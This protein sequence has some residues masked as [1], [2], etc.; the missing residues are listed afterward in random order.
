MRIG[1]V[2]MLLKDLF[3]NY[4]VKDDL[5]IDNLQND[6]RL[7]NI[8]SLFIAYTGFEK[9]PHLYIE[10]AYCNGCR[11]F[12]IDSDKASQFDG[13]YTD[14][15]FISSTDLKKEMVQVTLH[16]Y[17]YPDQKL[18]LIGV[19]GTNG[20]TTT[21]TVIDQSINIIGEKTAFFGTVEWRVGDKSY[22]ALNTTPD[23]LVLVKFLKQA[24]D[25]DI[26]YVVMEVASHALSLGRVDGL[27]FDFTVFTNLTQDHLD[28]H[29]TLEEY[30]KAKERLFVDLLAN[31]NKKNKKAFINADDLHGQRLLKILGERGVPSIA[32]SIEDKGYWN[33][34]NVFAS[35]YKTR[36]T[37][38]T[39]VESIIIESG[40][41]GIINV[42]NTMLAYA[43]LSCLGYDSQ[44]IVAAISTIVVPGRLQ[45]LEDSNGVVFLVDYAHTP[46]A[47]EKAISVVNDILET[48]KKSI[49]VFGAGGDR[50]KTKRPLMAKS[51]QNADVIIV[52]S[53]N[54]RTENPE[55]IISDI[56]QGFTCVNN[57]LQETN[58]AKAI[59]L[60]Y[61]QAE[62]GDVILIAGKGHEDYQ[63]IGTKKTH[64]SDVEEIQ[65]CID[66]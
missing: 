54:P 19:T 6:S 60:A 11:C 17:D 29:A 36:Y 3:P 47:L 5:I 14:A 31:S 62:S 44:N 57:V 15:V 45:R 8:N 30:Y 22:E 55:D 40:L 21:A 65:K 51:S 32:L 61:Q 20:K 2:I 4:S 18:T 49:V 48:G 58:R 26:A 13:K 63:I 24:V 10:D 34:T 43:V 59:S 37:L 12:L 33:A 1:E 7:V 50:D 39:P 64:F 27:N 25:C 9:D 23:F 66:K 56:M 53:D 52:T 46:D 28:F 35:A 38:V 41:L 42:Q 16:F